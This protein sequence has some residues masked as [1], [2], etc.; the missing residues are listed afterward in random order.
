MLMSGSTTNCFFMSADANH[1]AVRYPLKRKMADKSR[2][3]TI[4]ALAGT[5]DTQSRVAL[6]DLPALDLGEG[7]DRCQTRVLS[8]RERD[9]IEGGR[10]RAHRVLLDRGD[11]VG[12][13]GDGDRAGNLGSTAAVDDAVVAHEVADDAESVVQCALSLVDDL[14]ER[15]VGQTWRTAPARNGGQHAPSCSNREQ[16]R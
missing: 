7:L 2:K 10:E 15:S 1:V 3:L 14:E 16:R 11:L 9:G 6:G 13:G 8:E 5:V 4:L 12:F